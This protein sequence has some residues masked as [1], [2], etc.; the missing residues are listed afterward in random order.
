[1]Q[2]KRGQPTTTD[3]SAR[4]DADFPMS[5]DSRSSISKRQQQPAAEECVVGVR[6]LDHWP[7]TD[8]LRTD[9]IGIWRGC[10]LRASTSAVWGEA[11]V[12]PTLGIFSR[13]PYPSFAETDW[14][15]T[16]ESRRAIPDSE[17]NGPRSA[18]HHWDDTLAISSKRRSVAHARGRHRFNPTASRSSDAALEVLAER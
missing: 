16:G 6:L 8:A 10:G 12:L 17:L 3:R 14:N 18:K 4:C 1:M 15:V 9:A 13:D 11:A 7:C 5:L 2:C